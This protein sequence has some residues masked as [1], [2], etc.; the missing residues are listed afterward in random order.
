LLFDSNALVLNS[1]FSEIQNI[2]ANAEMMI[3]PTNASWEADVLYFQM[4]SRLMIMVS[5]KSKCS[6]WKV[7]LFFETNN[8]DVEI[9]LKNCSICFHFRKSCACSDNSN[10]FDFFEGNNQEA[11]RLF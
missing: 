10:P 4:I 6:Y 1:V 8:S 2:N 9:L 11:V 3:C 5:K 7:V